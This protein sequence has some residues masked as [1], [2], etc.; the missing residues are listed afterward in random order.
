MKV[1]DLTT[2]GYVTARYPL[3][4]RESVD[5]AMDSWKKFCAL[6]NDM[7]QVFSGGDRKRDFGYMLRQRD[8]GNADEK[9][10]FH[11]SMRDMGELMRIAS[12]E[13]CAPAISF[14]CATDD[15]IAMSMPLVL[16]FA[17]AVEKAY[18]LEDF[19]EDVLTND[20]TWT[21]R[22]LH[23]FGGETLAHA[24]ADRGGFTLH[25]A[26]S[27]PGGEYFGF[28]RAWHPWPVSEKQTIIFPSMNLQH[29]SRG[30]LK[31]LWHRVVPCEETREEGRYSMVAFIDFQH[32]H[33]LETKRLQEFEPGFNYSMGNEEF[34]ALFAE[35]PIVL[36]YPVS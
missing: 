32:T 16:E 27:H 17:S 1:Q 8:R 21:F 28:D 15:L 25:L 9:E 13:G 14:V 6:P 3:D 7:K 31:A 18:G 19:E 11:V 20:T 4:L 5:A 24:H 22:Y 30:A 33:K 23:Y 26:E 10:L 36:E 2:K 29:R 35:L 34:G 12:H